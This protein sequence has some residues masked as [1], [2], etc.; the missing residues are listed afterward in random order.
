MFMTILYSIADIRGLL[1]EQY[2]VYNKPPFLIAEAWDGSRIVDL[3]ELYPE[4]NKYRTVSAFCVMFVSSK[5]ANLRDPY[6]THLS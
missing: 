2:S 6:K 3:D 5:R 1:K 4:K